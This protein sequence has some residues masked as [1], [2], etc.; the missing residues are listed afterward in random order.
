MFEQVIATP[1]SA[2]LMSMK[3]KM[4][5]LQHTPRLAEVDNIDTT[6]TMVLAIVTL[7]VVIGLVLALTLAVMIGPTLTLVL[8][9]LNALA[10][11]VAKVLGIRISY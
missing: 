3:M 7:A 8:V 11:V 9:A 1:L 4:T 10:L 2:A 5:H 6:V